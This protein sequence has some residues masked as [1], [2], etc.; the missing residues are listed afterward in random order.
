MARNAN[1][2]QFGDVEDVYIS[3]FPHQI[4]Q[5]LRR[6]HTWKHQQSPRLVRDAV[7]FFRSLSF[8]VGSTMVGP[9]QSLAALLQLAPE[10]VLQDIAHFIVVLIERSWD[11]APDADFWVDDLLDDHAFSGSRIVPWVRSLLP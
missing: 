8:P 10:H 11:S 4:I 9:V 7:D 2:F 3:P 1:S 5:M 6:I